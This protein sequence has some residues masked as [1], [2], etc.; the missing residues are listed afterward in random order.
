M[1]LCCAN[2]PL[3]KLAKVLTRI[4]LQRARVVLCTLEW[5]PEGGHTLWRRLLD[6]MTVRRTDFLNGPSYV[7]EDSVKTMPAPKWGKFLSTVVGS[8]KPVPV[9]DLDQEVLK[10]LTAKNCSLNLL[11]LKK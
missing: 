11:D 7:R 2:P 3:C 6:C 8:L 9:Y 4:A 5:S 10:E 1:R